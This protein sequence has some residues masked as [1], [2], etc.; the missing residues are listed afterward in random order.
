MGILDKQ[1]AREKEKKQKQ[2]ALKKQQKIEKERLK[3]L[4]EL[5]HATDLSVDELTYLIKFIARTKFDGLEMQNIYSITA[6]LQNQLKNKLKW[7]QSGKN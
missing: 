7:E 6:K 2:E 4:K 1:R 3:K 5:K